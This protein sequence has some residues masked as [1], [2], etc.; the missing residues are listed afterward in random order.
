MLSPKLLAE[1]SPR[2]QLQEFGWGSHWRA[3]VSAGSGLLGAAPCGSPW[4]EQSRCHRLPPCGDTAAVRLRP[5]KP[6]LMLGG[7]T[8]NK[9]TG[10]KPWLRVNLLKPFLI[11]FRDWK[12][13][14]FLKS[15][16]CTCR[17][18][19]FQHCQNKNDWY[20]TDLSIENQEGEG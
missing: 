7:R 4:Q 12:V 11:G 6:R 18:P 17:R 20:F 15:M 2:R 5:G 16:K 13:E 9:A 8:R 19:N 10:K 3:A 14:R 1:L